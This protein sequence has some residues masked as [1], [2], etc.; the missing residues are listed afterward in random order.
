MFAHI[1]TMV[2]LLSLIT[3]VHTNRNNHTLV[4]P[5]NQCSHK[6]IECS[7]LSI[8]KFE[9]CAFSL[10]HL[11][12]LYVNMFLFTTRTTRMTNVFILRHSN[13]ILTEKLNTTVEPVLGDHPFCTAKA[14]SQDRWSLIAGRTQIMFYR[15]VHFLQRQP[16]P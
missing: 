1:E 13:M 12:P 10:Y 11:A 15:C 3:N 9:L 14:V 16:G 4:I 7:C 6:T 8:L 2:R 5:C